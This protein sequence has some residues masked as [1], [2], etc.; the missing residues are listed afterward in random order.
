M[1]TLKNYQQFYGLHWETG[2]LTNIFAYQGITAP[3]TGKPISEALLMGVNGGLCAGYFA[4][5]YEGY[6]PHLHF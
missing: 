3:H 5:D 2:F 4:F 1:P 6:D